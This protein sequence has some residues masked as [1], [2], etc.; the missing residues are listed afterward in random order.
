[1]IRA[2]AC[3]LLLLAA[4]CGGAPEQPA[5]PAVTENPVDAA[6]AGSITGKIV[7]DGMPPAPGPINMAS[8]PYCE[9]Q[10]GA[11]VNEYVTGTGGTLGN[12]FVYVKDGLGDL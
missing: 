7:L 6:T 11:T 8:D 12:V 4:G 9:S 3:A 5:A 10:G 1:M 2:G